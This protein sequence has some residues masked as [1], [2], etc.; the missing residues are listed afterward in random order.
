[1]RRNL[2]Q[3]QDC[4][5]N[6]DTMT[7]QSRKK[8]APVQ[9]GNPH[10]LTKN[11]HIFPKKGLERFAVADFVHVIL[12]SN[13]NPFRVSTKHEIFCAYRAWDQKA[14]KLDGKGVEDDFAKL[15]DQVV[16]GE[17][18]E[19]DASMN[20]VAVDFWD[21]MNERYKA[22]IT[23]L[24]D[25]TFPGTTAN[26]LTID[27][28]EQLESNYVSFVGPDGKMSGRVIAGIHMYGRRM[29]RR[30]SEVPSWGIWRAQEGEFIV[31]DSFSEGMGIPVSPS[32]WLI[33]NEPNRTLTFMDVAALNTSLVSQAHK[34]AFAR[35]FAKAPVLE[36]AGG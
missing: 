9:K 20:M 26:N 12:I 30:R 28:Q 6:F 32:I 5:D 4:H 2:F 29:Y 13:P 19:L 3:Y 27:Q 25:V 35:D 31:P 33:A 21:L 24:E 23:P 18:Q 8:Q 36:R 1:M 14:E 10:G 22:H 11:Q 15:A 17:V 7:S 34:Y 16:S